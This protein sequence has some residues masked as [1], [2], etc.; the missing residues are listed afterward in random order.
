MD[1]LAIV[2]HLRRDRLGASLLGLGSRDTRVRLGLVR[3]K[4]SANILADV[5]VGDVDGNDGESRVCVQAT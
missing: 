1:R 3:L 4:P 5:D 2:T